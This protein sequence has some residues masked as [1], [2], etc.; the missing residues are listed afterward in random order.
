LIITLSTPTQD[1]P[2][3]AA[4]VTASADDDDRAAGP[5]ADRR[6]RRPDD[7][8]RRAVCT[9]H[10]DHEQPGPS[11]RGEQ[12]RHWLFR[13]GADV[14]RHLGFGSMGDGVGVGEDL[15]GALPPEVGDG[16][17]A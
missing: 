10:S 3:R 16:R 15:V 1:R 14:D 7:D 5:P 6:R 17:V 8:V 13:R 9:A 2:V 4:R 12:R 11:G